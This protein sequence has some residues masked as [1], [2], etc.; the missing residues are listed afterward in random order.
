MKSD[1][2]KLGSGMASE[3]VVAEEDVGQGRMF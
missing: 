3:M 2:E 1:L